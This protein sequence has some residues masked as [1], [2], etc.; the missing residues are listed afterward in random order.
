MAFGRL[1]SGGS[2]LLITSSNRS[3]ELIAILE[4]SVL[5]LFDTLRIGISDRSRPVDS[6]V[7][8]PL[9]KNRYPLT[10]K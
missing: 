2:R 4:L 10:M 5:F 3:F 9:N 8:S 6:L 1:L 7:Y